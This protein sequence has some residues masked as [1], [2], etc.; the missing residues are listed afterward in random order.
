MV[1][2]IKRLEAVS[3]ILRIASAALSPLNRKQTLPVERK[4]SR[5][6]SEGFGVRRGATTTTS[7]ISDSESSGDRPYRVHHTPHKHRTGS[8]AVGSEECHGL[9]LDDELGVKLRV[10]TNGLVLTFCMKNSAP[11]PTT[12]ENDG[13]RKK[14]LSIVSRGFQVSVTY[15]LP[16]PTEKFHKPRACPPALKE[17]RAGTELLNQDSSINSKIIGFG[18]RNSTT[19]GIRVITKNSIEFVTAPPT[20]ASR[21][22]S[23]LPR[24]VQSVSRILARPTP[25]PIGYAAALGGADPPPRMEDTPRGREFHQ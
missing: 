12:A 15:S 16:V 3:H 13:I 14:N 25:S 19:A 7:F 1:E 6:G 23:L 2:A 22:R 21:E 10:T 9:H 17:E 18:R 20:A 24:T 8:K 5:D 11:K 4:K